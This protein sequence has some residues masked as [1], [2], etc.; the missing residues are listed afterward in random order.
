VT[1]AF[2]LAAVRAKAVRPGTSFEIIREIRSNA[3]TQTVA[4]QSLAAA[5]SRH[6]KLLHGGIFVHV[7]EAGGFL[8]LETD[9]V[10]HN[11]LGLHLVS[12]TV[13]GRPAIDSDRIEDCIR[14]ALVPELANT[15]AEFAGD[16]LSTPPSSAVSLERRFV[17]G[18][19]PGD[20]SGY[21]GT[22]KSLRELKARPDEYSE[23]GALVGALG[24]WPIRY[25]LTMPLY[26]AN[27]LI[28]FEVARSKHEDLMKEFAR[29]MGSSS[30]EQ[31]AISIINHVLSPIGTLVEFRERISW[32]RRLDEFL[33][34][35]FN[36]A[37]ASVFRV[38]KSISTIPLQ[39]APDS[40]T[41]EKKCSVF[42]L[43][44]LD[45]RWVRP[46]DGPWVVTEVL[47]AE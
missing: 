33:E 5:K 45:V 10:T 23:Y 40:D 25:S 38:N 42:T 22:L 29:G 32:L 9:P 15:A 14:S 47:P 41:P 13:N 46:D 18:R 35:A 3:E 8:I 31:S 19:F 24:L 37:D 36:A 39:L 6:A 21:F 1:A 20:D 7:L 16:M 44:A 17:G 4:R 43:P 34:G 28:A 27:P 26:A 12:R 2:A 11:A 30:E